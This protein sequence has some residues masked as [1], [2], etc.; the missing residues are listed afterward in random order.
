MSLIAIPEFRFVGAPE[1]NVTAWYSHLGNTAQFHCG[2]EYESKVRRVDTHGRVEFED[3]PVLSW[4]LSDRGFSAEGKHFSMS[5]IAQIFLQLVE[6][7]R[8]MRV[9]RYIAEMDVYLNEAQCAVPGNQYGV[10]RL[11][12]THKRDADYTL[13]RLFTS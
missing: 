1:H 3:M 10:S 5:K 13:S 7:G 2:F 11:S 12:P 8:R 4:N 6:H 9:G